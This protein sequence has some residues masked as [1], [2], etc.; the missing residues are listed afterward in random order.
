MK[1]RTT[2]L[3]FLIAVLFLSGI[4]A[5]SADPDSSRP[6]GNGQKQQ[7]DF[8]ANVPIQISRPGFYLIRID[9]LEMQFRPLKKESMERR[10]FVRWLLEEKND[11]IPI[12]WTKR[13]SELKIDTLYSFLIGLN[14]IRQPSMA[15]RWRKWAEPILVFSTIS[16]LVYLFYS[17]RSK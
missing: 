7:W 12:P 5:V 14:P 8:P 2:H 6:F 13:T 10:T 3:L 1:P 17:I 9:S 4:R 16:S 11:S 15:S